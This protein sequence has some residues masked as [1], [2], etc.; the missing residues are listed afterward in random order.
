MMRAPQSPPA[1]M[2]NMFRLVAALRTGKRIWLHCRDDGTYEV[3]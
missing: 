1:W 3:L 2:V